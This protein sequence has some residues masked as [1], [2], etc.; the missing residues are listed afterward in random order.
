MFRKLLFWWIKSLRFLVQSCKYDFKNQKRTSNVQ[1]FGLSKFLLKIL[2]PINFAVK[3]PKPQKNL[4]IAFSTDLSQRCPPPPP[5][6]AARLLTTRCTHICL[7]II[8]KLHCHSKLNWK[9]SFYT[10]IRGQ[11]ISIYQS[12]KIGD[13]YSG[14]ALLIIT[15]FLL[16]KPKF[17]SIGYS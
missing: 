17:A 16:W 10:F 5:A 9:W 12:A 11:T 4:K 2:P 7:K 15:L 14:I 8:K 1:Y 3:H 6:T 13:Y